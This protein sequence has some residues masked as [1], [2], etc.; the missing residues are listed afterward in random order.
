MFRKFHFF[1]CILLLS[2]IFCFTNTFADENGE[3][4]DPI[5][6][7]NIIAEDN[8]E[9]PTA[10][11]AA[12]IQGNA[13]YQ[14]V[15]DYIIGTPDFE[16]MRDLPTDSPDYQLGRKVGMLFTRDRFGVPLYLYGVPGRA[17]SVYD[18]PPLCL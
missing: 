10:D 11:G 5:N 17:R 18:K 15:P 2:S 1:L 12:Y 7:E 9:F 8:F 6:I 3:P 14:R 16:K 13:E 4:L